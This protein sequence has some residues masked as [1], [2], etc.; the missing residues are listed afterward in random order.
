MHTIV[1]LI[2]LFDF[3]SRLMLVTQVRV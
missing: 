1:I 3:D 2:Q